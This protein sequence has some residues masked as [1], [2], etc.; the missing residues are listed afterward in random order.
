MLHDRRLKRLESALQR[1]PADALSAT[2]WASRA[3]M[4]PRTFSRLFQRD[5]GMPFRQWRQQLRLLAALRRLAAEQR[6]NQVALELGYESTSAFVAMFR[7]ALGT[8]PGR[9]FTM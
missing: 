4:S 7:R 5:T 1:N 8:T 9:Y 2:G 3:G 6:V